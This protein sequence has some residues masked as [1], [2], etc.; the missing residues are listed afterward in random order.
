MGKAT[1]TPERLTQQE[2]NEQSQLVAKV[3][4][5]NWRAVRTVPAVKPLAKKTSLSLEKKK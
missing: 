3:N 5:K 4:G 2:V 1:V